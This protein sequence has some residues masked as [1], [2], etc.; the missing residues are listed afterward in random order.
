[1]RFVRS[2]NNGK[3]AMQHGVYLYFSMEGG[4]IERYYDQRM[5]DVVLMLDPVVKI[6]KDS[7][8]TKN[9]IIFSPGATWELRKMDDVVIERPP[10]ISLMGVNED[11]L[12]RDEISQT[13]ALGE[14]IQGQPQAP[15]EPLGKVAVLLG[16]SNLRLSMN[17]QNI[18]VALT[19]VANILIQ[20]NQEFIGEDK[21]YRLV[22]K[23]VD[24]KEFKKNDKKVVVDAIVE[25][26]PVFPPDKTT[27]LN[28]VLLMYDNLLHRISRI[29]IIL[30]KLNVG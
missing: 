2:E 11:K 1:M 19:T 29:R 20:L 12:L 3:A 7:G 15:D 14:Y 28:Q 23:S 8:I 13:L 10:E 26:E 16:Q 18:A 24:F 30:K 21:L 9:D 25:V 4:M 5:D 6:R 22:G 27:R 17:A